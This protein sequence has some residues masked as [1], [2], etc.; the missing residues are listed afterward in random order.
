MLVCQL[1]T[2]SDLVMLLHGQ[3]QPLSRI[4]PML[5]QFF[6]ENYLS[7]REP[8]DQNIAVSPPASCLQIFNLDP[9]FIGSPASFPQAAADSLVNELEEYITE[10][11][12]SHHFTSTKQ[13]SH[14]HSGG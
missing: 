8:T 11:F 3:H 2:M 9:L 7:G 14:L 6:T 12:V 10:S 4:Q 13:L 5:S 1:F